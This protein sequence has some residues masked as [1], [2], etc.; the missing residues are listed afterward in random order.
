MRHSLQRGLAGEIEVAMERELLEQTWQRQTQDFQ[1]GLQA[2]A[3][4]RS[5]VFIGQ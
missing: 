4:R 1:E 5:P 2:M 3:E